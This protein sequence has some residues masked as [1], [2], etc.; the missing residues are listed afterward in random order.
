[1]DYLFIQNFIYNLKNGTFNVKTFSQ[2][3][4]RTI[5]N[6]KLYLKKERLPRSTK[7]KVIQSAL[8]QYYGWIYDNTL[9]YNDTLDIDDTIS[10]LLHEY[11]HWIRRVDGTYKYN[12]DNNIFIEEFFAELISEF[13][14][15]VLNNKE[16]VI[17]SCI[18][19]NTANHII[20]KYKLNI[21]KEKAIQLIYDN[22]PTVY[23]YFQ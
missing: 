9:Y 11:V 22:L 1:M 15:N 18:I 23:K 5:A 10:T 6:V 7:E 20:S 12:S 16:A 17:T 13:Y 3:D 2:F 21:K 4:N 19:N 8:K 14:I